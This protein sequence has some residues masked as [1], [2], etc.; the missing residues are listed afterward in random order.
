MTE[1]SL[2]RI[3]K[4]IALGGVF[5]THAADE[6]PTKWPDVWLTPDE[7][8]IGPGQPIRLPPEVGDVTPGPEITA[9]VGDRLERASES[10]AADAIKGFTLSND[11]TA[12][13]E[14]PGYSYENH[15][16]ITGTGYKIFPTFRPVLTEYT[17]IDPDDVHGR[18]VEATIDGQV[19]VSGST[20][21]MSFD[22]GEAVAHASKIVSL[23]EDDLIALGDPGSPTG[24][25]D[26]ATEV[27][28]TIEG[29][30]EL[31]NPVERIDS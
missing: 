15:E 5:S 28:C 17:E 22:V 23:E 9:V 7:A 2:S 3:G 16:V 18:K 6:R 11:V 30:G 8:R 31:T 25:L 12:K 1:L 21:A 24:Y 27:T 19:V 20:D 14:W 29:I 26:D 4:F 13:G 10:E